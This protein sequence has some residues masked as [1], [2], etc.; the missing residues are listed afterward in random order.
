MYPG[1]VMSANISRTTSPSLTGGRSSLI[2]LANFEPE[3]P[4]LKA[5]GTFEGEV[6]VDAIDIIKRKIPEKIIQLKELVE[7]I[8][9]GI[10]KCL[11]L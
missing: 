10:I 4:A 8:D 3:A 1:V 2:T 6:V 11:Y 7:V 5:I 9:N